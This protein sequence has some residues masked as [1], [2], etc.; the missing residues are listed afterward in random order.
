MQR[1]GLCC[2]VVRT[3]KEW[4]ETEQGISLLQGKSEI[5]PVTIE[6]IGNFNTI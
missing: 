6:K 2:V 4:K 3:S 5:N 1:V